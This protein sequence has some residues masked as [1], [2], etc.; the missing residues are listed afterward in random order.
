M[1]SIDLKKTEKDSVSLSAIL[2]LL[3][4][5]GT[6]DIYHK[7]LPLVSATTYICTQCQSRLPSPEYCTKCIR[8]HLINNF[9]NWTSENKE[10]D[11]MLQTW[12]IN[13]PIPGHFF[14]WVP[15]VNF[16]NIEYKTRGRY[17]SIYTAT[18]VNGLIIGW[19]EKT[20]EFIRLGSKKIVLK[21]LNNSD[22]LNIRFFE[23][24]LSSTVSPT[25]ASCGVKCYGLTKYPDNGKYMLILEYMENGDLNT[26][27]SN[28]VFRWEEVYIILGQI[29]TELYYIHFSNIVHKNLHPRNILSNSKRW[30]ISDFGFNG[31]ADNLVDHVFEILPYVAP[32]VLYYKKCTPASN[33]YSIGIIMWQLATRCNNPY[34]NRKNDIHLAIDICNGLRPPKIS[35]V[36]PDYEYIMRKCL[37]A[38]PLQRPD[39]CGLCLYFNTKVY[40]INHDKYV[41]PISKIKIFFSDAYSLS[42][43]KCENLEFKYLPIPKNSINMQSS[44]NIDDK[45]H[46]ISYIYR[47]D[48]YE[49]FLQYEQSVKNLNNNLK[50]NYEHEIFLRGEIYHKLSRFSSSLLVVNN[51]LLLNQPREF[52][53]SLNMV[54]ELDPNNIYVIECR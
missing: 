38:D 30:S 32:E 26:F 18:W 17:G 50:I 5:D 42:N 54:L 52:L 48:I 27:I 31:P 8:D 1:A 33:I 11:R 25:L 19:N 15:F 7:P 9:A 36:P 34:G 20:Q 40:K 53:K 12:Q 13:F 23:E 6:V 29:F 21:L 4:G 39:A 22:N 45:R 28:N 35:D 41:F 37:D 47:G 51:T 43:H 24:A 10:I 16:N 44:T 49:H 14:E 2:E 3:E 46:T